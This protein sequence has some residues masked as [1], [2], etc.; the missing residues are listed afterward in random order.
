MLAMLALRFGR[1]CTLGVAPRGHIVGAF[2]PL[3]V[4]NV[5]L[6]GDLGGQPESEESEQTE[7]GVHERVVHGESPPRRER[8]QG[9]ADCRSDGARECPGRLPNAVDGA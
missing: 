1:C 7:N 8:E 3:N 9:A 2:L 6:R 5:Q 4:R